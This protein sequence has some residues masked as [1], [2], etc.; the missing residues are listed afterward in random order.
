M[1][2]TNIANLEDLCG[3]IAIFVAI[4]QNGDFTRMQDLLSDVLAMVS[5]RSAVSTGLIAGGAWAIRVARYEGLKF[6][7]VIRGEAWL[8]VEGHGEPLHLREGDCFVLTSGAAFVIASDL[9]VVPVDA[10]TVFAQAA[11]PV[12]RHGTG[13]DFHVLGGKMMLDQGDA[14]LL[15]EG[16]PG[17]IHI[18]GQSHTAGHLQWLLTRLLDEMHEARPG[19]SIMAAQL[20]QML[21]IESLRAHLGAAQAPANGWLG[22]LAEPRIRNA[23][24]AMHAAPSQPWTIGALASIACMSRSNFSLKFKT[25][26]G[27]APLDYLLRWRMR[28]ACH[29]LRKT[30]MPVSAIAQSLGYASDS[31]FSNAFKR[32]HGQ[33]PLNYRNTSGAIPAPPA[34]PD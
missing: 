22:A 7:A 24:Q 25:R 34:Y 30:R 20:M 21:F 3:I 14:G 26:V 28:L 6:N 10:D 18:A 31:A 5:A 15:L 33:S 12:A 13:E 2:H 11:G 19:Q 16:L 4:V 17:I 8:A 32:L 27:L 23:M 29:S 9:Q 1:P